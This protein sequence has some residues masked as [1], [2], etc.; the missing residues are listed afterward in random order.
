MGA[1]PSAAGT[2][3]AQGHLKQI[4]LG[5]AAQVFPSPELAFGNAAALFDENLELVDEKAI[6]RLDSFIE[7]FVP[8]VRKVR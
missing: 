7:K 4:L 3:R 6:L 1:S 5:M 2:V 8:W